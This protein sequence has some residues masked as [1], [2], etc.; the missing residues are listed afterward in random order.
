MKKTAMN[1]AWAEVRASADTK[2]PM[3]SEASTKGRV[4][5]ESVTQLPRGHTPK[6]TPAAAVETNIST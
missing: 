6:I 3:A 1:T 5:T 2:T 4:A